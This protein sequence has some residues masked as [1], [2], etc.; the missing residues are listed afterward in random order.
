M[1]LTYTNLTVF[2]A[3]ITLIGSAQPFLIWSINRLYYRQVDKKAHAKFCFH[4]NYIKCFKRKRYVLRLT[5]SK[6][7]ALFSVSS[8]KHFSLIEQMCLFTP[9]KIPLLTINLILW[10]RVSSK[11]YNMYLV[12]NLHL[13]FLYSY[14]CHYI[15]L[16]YITV[17]TFF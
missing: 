13:F 11:N 15:T 16:H 1:R 3:V 12:A 14:K 5:F 6:V 9:T 10:N 2:K 7:C 8:F 4:S 17:Y